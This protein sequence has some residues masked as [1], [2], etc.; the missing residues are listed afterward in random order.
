[1]TD[2]SQADHELIRHYLAGSLSDEEEVMLE[3]RIV[4]D[5]QFRH[6]LDL[7]AAL[8]EGMRELD[9]RGEIDG[10][11]TGARAG[12]QRYR[13]TM[14]AS[15]GV[16]AVTSLTVFYLMDR[17]QRP[18]KVAATA[19]LHFERTRGMS[20]DNA[21]TWTPGATPTRLRL[22]FDV[23]AVPAAY[24]RVVILHGNG[25]TAEPIVTALTSASAEG[26]VI[27]DLEDPLL[28]PGNLEIRLTPVPDSDETGTTVYRLVVTDR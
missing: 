4:R 19:S 14:A 12:W 27:L 11:L 22:H 6:E 2:I 8:R 1:M 16:L 7:T 28:A 24:Y 18:E 10:L 3:T 26:E 21:V 13:T 5:A 9:S 17:P 25:R 23:G 15:I 20:S